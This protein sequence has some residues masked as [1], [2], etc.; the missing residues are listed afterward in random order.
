VARASWHTRLAAVKVLANSRE[1]DRFP[2]LLHAL[3]DRS[4]FVVAAAADVLAATPSPQAIQPLI[5]RYRWLDEKGTTRDV[6]CAARL[7][8][9]SALTACQASEA[10][11]IYLRAI[12][13]IQIEPSGMGVE[14]VAVPLRMKAATALATFRLPGALLALA[15]L[16]VDDVAMARSAAVQALV[17]LGDPAAA[18]LL[19]MRLARPTDEE[20]EILVN[21][22]DA[23]VD[24][25]EQ[26]ALEL[27]PR[28]LETADPYLIAGAA[29]ALASL[30]PEY[31]TQVL[32]ILEKACNRAAAQAREAIILAVAS[33]RSEAVTASLMRLAD[34]YDEGV[35]LATV[36]ALELR[37]DADSQKVLH[38]LAQR[39]TDRQVCRAAKQALDRLYSP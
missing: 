13:T 36:P 3:D 22:M 34:H 25:D 24:L 30:G 20:P 37:A 4:N 26:V 31:H 10:D 2:A 16:L 1:P 18:A 14:D 12:K 17:H 35:R 8:I 33:M 23:L 5:K 27:I 28:F 29:T 6:T 38:K 7:A 11:G 39:T 15:I 21:C 32:S 9:V 19:G